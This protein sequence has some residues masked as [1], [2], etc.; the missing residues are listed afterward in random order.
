MKHLPLLLIGCIALATA[1]R[2][3]KI[4][5]WVPVSGD[6]E[7]T[8][9]VVAELSD[10]ADAENRPLWIVAPGPEAP[11]GESFSATVTTRDGVGDVFLAVRWR[12]RD[13]F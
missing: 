7:L 12:N 11:G 9:G 10:S 4:S 3:D 6:W 5:R 1:A 13:N 8:D 2:A